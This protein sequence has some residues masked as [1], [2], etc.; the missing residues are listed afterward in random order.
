[1]VVVSTAS[2]WRSMPA[3]AASRVRNGSSLKPK[4]PS[5]SNVYSKVTLVENGRPG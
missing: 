1:M 4:A 5:P 2:V 3:V